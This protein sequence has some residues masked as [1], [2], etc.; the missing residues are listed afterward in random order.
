MGDQNYKSINKRFLCFIRNKTEYLKSD[1]EANDSQSISQSV[2]QF[3]SQSVSQIFTVSYSHSVCLSI[4]QSACISS[5][6]QYSC[7]ERIV[8][9]SE[10]V[11]SS[12]F[13]CQSFSQSFR[14]TVNQSV[15]ELVCSVCQRVQSNSFSVYQSLSLSVGHSVSQSNS[16]AEDNRT[17]LC[18][19]R[20]AAQAWRIQEK[21]KLYQNCKKTYDI[22]RILCTPRLKYPPEISTQLFDKYLTFPQLRHTVTALLHSLVSRATFNVYLESHKRNKSAAKE[23]K[24]DKLFGCQ[25]HEG[26]DDLVPGR[27]RPRQ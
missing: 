7:F 24:P 12:K 20:V 16:L 15:S 14:Q 2:C 23:S 13:V 25:L 5:V 9:Q 3:V 26:S 4:C 22:W 18:S 17:W 21:K 1:R 10:W 8:R 19:C 11:N 6:S 27:S